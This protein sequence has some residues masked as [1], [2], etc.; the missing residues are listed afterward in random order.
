MYGVTRMEFSR[1]TLMSVTGSTTW[2]LNTVDWRN[3]VAYG[4]SARLMD[5]ADK[6]SVNVR[7]WIELL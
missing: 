6:A 7:R 5:K 3:S 4:E 2:I 1:I